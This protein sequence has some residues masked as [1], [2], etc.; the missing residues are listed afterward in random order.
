MG[1]RWD[2]RC[3]APH[4]VTPVAIDPSGV[5]GP[6]R[7]Q[8]YGPKWR[9]TGRGL[10]VPVGVDRQAVEQ[11]ILEQWSRTP[12]GSVVSGWA[13]LRLHGANFFDGRDGRMQELPVP[14]VLP[15]GT[16][17][18]EAGVERHRE[19]IPPDEVVDRYGIL[20]AAQTR[21]LFDAMKW[22]PDLRAAIVTADM[23]LAP[24]VV[25]LVEMEGYVAR[26]AGDRGSGRAGAA[27]ALAEPRTKS[28]KESVMRQ[29]WMVEAKL[30]RPRCNWPLADERGR[31]IGKPD[32]LCEE[33]AVVG[34][35]DGADHRSAQRQADDVSKEDGY[36]NVGLECFRI[37]GRDIE[38]VPLVVRRM[39]A[40]VDRSAEARRPGRWTIRKHPGPL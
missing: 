36:R 31:R 32:L 33:L 24:L 35:Y 37:V 34:E 40:A 16:N 21:A 28:P 17:V 2:L 9:R 14:V 22:A 1:H 39:R 26:R 8:A 15:P 7:A 11:R 29:I 4:L 38:N 27:L 5:D 13:A 3:P 19:P 6:T 20:C 23:A 10:F 18:R 12:S 25:T 30:P